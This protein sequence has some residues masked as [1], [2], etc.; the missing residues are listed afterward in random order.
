MAEDSSREAHAGCPLAAL[1]KLLAGVLAGDARGAGE[2]LRRSQ[3]ELLKGIRTW[4]DARIAEL[5]A[6]EEK[7]SPKRRRATRIRVD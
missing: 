4:L 3:L 1:A 2:H 7:P 6:G 5:E